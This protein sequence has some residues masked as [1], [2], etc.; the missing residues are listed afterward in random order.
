[1]HACK[2]H[3]HWIILYSIVCS[4][5]H[6]LVET[7]GTVIT[8]VTV[9]TDGTVVTDMT[10]MTDGTVVTNVTV[11]TDGTVVTDVTQL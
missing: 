4:E 5:Q 10:V 2:C 8:D 11:I 3:N 6:H 1:M 7:G 9:V